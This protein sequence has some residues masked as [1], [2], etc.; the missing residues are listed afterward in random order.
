MSSTSF[1]YKYFP[2]LF[3]LNAYTLESTIRILASSL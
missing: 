1:P 2:H 3:V